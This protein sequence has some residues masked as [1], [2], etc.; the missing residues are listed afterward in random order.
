MS[1]EDEAPVP[2]APPSW[3]LVEK[4]YQLSDRH[5]PDRQGVR[6]PDRAPGQGRGLGIGIQA[7]PVHASVI[8]VPGPAIGC[9]GVAAL[10]VLMRRE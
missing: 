8:G 10:T 6:L 1:C 5:G 2:A 9:P 3:P 4:R 7:T